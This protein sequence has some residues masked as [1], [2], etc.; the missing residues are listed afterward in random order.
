MLS[1]YLDP[2]NDFA[3]KKVFG[4]EKHKNIPIHFLNAVFNLK[5]E[6]QIINLQFLNPKQPP[7]IASRKESVVD[8][9]VEDQRGIKYIVEMQVAKIGGFEKRAQY[10]AAKTYCSGFKIANEYV[11]L[12]RVV[13]LAITDYIVFPK[14]DYYK[15]DHM[16]L[17]TRSQENDLKDFYY[18]F[19]EL[20]KF[21]KT[22]DEL[23][24][25]EEKWYYFLKHADERNDIY[26]ILDENPA[27]K[28]A[29]QVLDRYHWTEDELLWYEK[30]DMNVADEKGMVAA[31]F[32]E[33]KIA[34]AQKM[35]Q[36]NRP[37]QEIIEDTGLS[38][39][40][41]EDLCAA[42]KARCAHNA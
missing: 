17:D 27:I 38:K 40:E 35:L 11:S 26:A 4:E 19:V 14:K 18:T 6:D 24:T 20:P 39:K 22:I 28:E 16:T 30:V 41:V 2:K 23:E 31:A 42:L 37:I 33:G 36:R 9:L 10:Y 21:N 7:E 25:L 34:C 13:F 8:V 29:Y 15:S 3:F 32:H 5:D 1:R 12:K